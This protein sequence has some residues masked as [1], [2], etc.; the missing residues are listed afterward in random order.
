MVRNQT[1][2]LTTSPLS[3][4]WTQISPLKPYERQWNS[5]YYGKA[6]QSPTP[7]EKHYFDAYL[8]IFTVLTR[9]QYHWSTIRSRPLPSSLRLRFHFIGP[10]PKLSHDFGFDSTIRTL[11]QLSLSNMTKF[12]FA[13]TLRTM[14]QI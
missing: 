14:D 8:N 2:L 7:L 11:D 6:I 5:L 13:L 9:T 4:I 10:I 12:V 1:L 3:T